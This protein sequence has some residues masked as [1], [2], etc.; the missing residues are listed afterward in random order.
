MVEYIDREE[1]KQLIETKNSSF[2]I[3]DCRD[4]DFFTEGGAIS[5]AIN[6]PSETFDDK[7]TLEKLHSKIK[8]NNINQVIFHCFK[9][10]FRGPTCAQTYFGYLVDNKINDIIKV[11]VLTS[12]Y[13][14][15]KSEYSN[16]PNL[17]NYDLYSIESIPSK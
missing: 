9:S 17:I 5:T 12:G 15:W 6:V 2:L 3:V 4:D 14:M 1:L 10:Q 13:E 8:S 7:I 16:N 11:Q